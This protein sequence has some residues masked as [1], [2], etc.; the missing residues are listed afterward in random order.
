MRQVTTAAKSTPKIRRRW[1]GVG[2][3]VLA[4]GLLAACSSNSS[5]ST[6]TTAPTG[7]TGAPTTT[8][9]GSGSSGGLD[10][11][12]SGISRSSNATFSATYL[13][14]EA[15]TGKTETVTFAQSP[16]K[17][18]V[19]TTEGSFYIDGTSITECQGTGSSATCTT[20]PASMS[21]T[22][23][24]LTNLFNPGVIADTLKGVEAEAA[25]KSAGYVISTS[26]ATFGGQSSSCVSARGT[27]E[28]TPVTYCGSR[29]NGILTYVNANGNTVVLQAYTANPPAS[30]FAPP[31]GATV[32]TLPAGA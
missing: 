6:T 16:P 3:M 29:S 24:G 20:L 9:A 1:S 21:A 7:S 26:S 30:T 13:I 17:S 28:P 18:A 25:A 15:T 19:T 22:V 32:Q 23:S 4:G 11:L 12:V 27:S 14:T 5:S 10:S 31:A 2:A 8:A